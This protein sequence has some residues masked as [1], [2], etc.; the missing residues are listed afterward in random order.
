MEMLEKYNVTPNSACLADE[1][2]MKVYDD[3]INNYQVQY[4]AGG[5]GQNTIRVAQWMLQ[6]PKAAAFL[7][8]VGK[9]QTGQTLRA[10][11]EKDDVAVYYHEDDAAPT[12]TCACLINKHER[13][14]ITNLAAANNYKLSHL[15]REDI[16]AVMNNAKFFYITGFFLTVS[17]DSIQT[18]AKHALENNKIFTMNLSA[19]FISQFFSEPLMAA[20]PYVDILFGNESEAEAFAQ[21]MGYEDTSAQAVAEKIAA[22]P[23][24]GSRPRI[25]VITQGPKCTVISTEGKTFTVDV[26]AVPAES[27][28]DVNGAGDAFVGGFLS[29]LVKG[30]D[31]ETC[32]K[33]GHYAASVILKVSGTV[34]SGKP[35]FQA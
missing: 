30:K 13:A 35:E 18:V 21:K 20:M 3:L 6:E 16:T 8:S 27:I 12:G 33:A 15:Q 22:L 7:G 34:L 29:Q 14:L 31:L 11:A 26:P 23:K 19:P 9:D 28:V 25:A 32:A 2:Q 4:I 10:Q 5:A 1:K 17:P 24:L